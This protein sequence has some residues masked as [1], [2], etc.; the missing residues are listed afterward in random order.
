MVVS[1]GRH[2]SAI[3]SQ[4]SKPTSATSSGT[5]RPDSRSVSATPRAIWSLPQNTASNG[6]PARSRM[7]AGVA[8]PRLA[9]LAPQRPAGGE[10]LPGR[11][12]RRARARLAQPGREMALRAR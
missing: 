11:G 10:V 1:G 6:S 12:E 4:L 9:P 5:R 8:A 7:C 3:T 2:A